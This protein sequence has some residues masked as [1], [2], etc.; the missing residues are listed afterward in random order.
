MKAALL[1]TIAIVGASPFL[2]A[3]S[4]PEAERAA[5]EKQVLDKFNAEVRAVRDNRR[6]Q[7][8]LP[9]FEEKK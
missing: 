3:C 8:G 7:L 6:K 2:N 1:L 4:N 5:K 9:P